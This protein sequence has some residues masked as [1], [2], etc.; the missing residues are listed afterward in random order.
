MGTG[1]LDESSTATAPTPQIPH[2]NSAG[3]ITSF[4]SAKTYAKNRFKRCP[5][6]AHPASIQ[7]EPL[8]GV[9]S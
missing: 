6:S 3:R 7:Q 5:L 2:F 8:Y 4:H 1:M 9:P